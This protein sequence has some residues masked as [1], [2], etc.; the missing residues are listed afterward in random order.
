[1]K[2]KIIICTNSYPPNFMGGAELIAHHQAKTLQ[3]LG[4]TVVIFTGD[5]DTKKKRYSMK[6]TDYDGLSVY[7]VYLS[8]EDY[9]FR[10]NNFCHKKVEKIF[11]ALLDEFSPDVVHMHNLIG[12]SLGMIHQAKR[13]GIKTVMTLHD[14]WG[15]CF[16]STILKNDEHI[17]TCFSECEKCMP[18]VHEEDGTHIPIRMRQDYFSLHM[19]DVDT[20]ITPSR[21]ISDNYIKAGFPAEKF[22][23]IW[24]GIDIE[25]FAS[26]NRIPS[27]GVTRF[28]FIG[29]VGR[30]K[31]AHVL[32]DALL[33]LDP[34]HRVQINIVG[35][36]D[37]LRNVK[38]QVETIG[39]EDSVRFWGKVDHRRIEKIY[40]ETD[41]LVVP[42]IWPENQPV[43]ITEAMA[44]RIPVIAS[45]VGG[46]P[47][48]VEDGVTGLLCKKGDARELAGKMTEILARPEL[49][50]EFGERG[51]NKIMNFSY[52]NQ[53]NKILQ[54]YNR[55]A[56]AAPGSALPTIACVGNRLKPE[57]F[58]TFNPI[59]RNYNG[60]FHF[61]IGEWMTKEQLSGAKIIWVIDAHVTVRNLIKGITAHRPLL[62]PEVN[63]ELRDFCNRNN[64]GLYYA[65]TEEA[66]E[67]I[68]YI[69]SHEGEAAVIAGNCGRA[70]SVTEEEGV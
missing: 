3:R 23:V 29:Y 21:H 59:K 26:L 34:W 51:F 67:C 58:L 35:T 17:C 54:V 1:M 47:E 12:L 65:D 38:K 61:I 25:R 56:V 48:L 22:E 42:S 15:F 6:K 28:T 69:M 36:G 62:V 13:R 46:I 24:N 63:T 14:N 16:K 9:N 52:Q 39:K 19:R 11:E 18:Y 4:H 37:E 41:V 20:F 2:K 66:V 68:N 40:H 33:H 64:C 60:S 49:M 53:V 7:R 32:V 5:L 10:Y 31:G 57:F 27:R 43:T 45:N 30:H 70:V 8:Y 44:A 55:P 50:Q